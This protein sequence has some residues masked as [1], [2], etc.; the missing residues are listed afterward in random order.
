M[1]AVITF[2]HVLA[3]LLLIII[4]LMQSGRG[5]GLTE[6][7]S[8]SAE[9]MFGANTSE[10]LIKGTTILASIFLVTSLS[11]AFLSTTKDK[12]LITSS[13]AAKA[14]KQAN[15]SAEQPKTENVQA[16]AGSAEVS[17]ESN[18]PAAANALSD[19]QTVEPAAVPQTE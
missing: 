14:Q 17:V 2:I 11:L 12:S 7:F 15:A 5:G 9:S 10:V 1:A 8:S 19:I 13:V 18:I 6:M 16:V 4:I 3:C